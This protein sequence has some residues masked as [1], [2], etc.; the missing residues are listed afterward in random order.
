VVSDAPYPPPPPYGQPVPRPP[1]NGLAVAALVLGILAL[2]TAPIPLVNFLGLVLALVG[3]GLGIA[4]ITR[5]RRVGRR[6]GMAAWGLGLS[7]VALVVSTVVGF[8][9]VRYLGDLLDTVDPPDPSASIGEEFETDDGDLRITVTSVECGSADGADC[10]FSFDARNTSDR[11]L[12]LDN[13]KVKAVVDGEWVDPSL[14]GGLTL[15]PDASATGSGSVWL[16]GGTLE[17][18]AFDADDASSHSAV[19]VDV[20]KAESGQ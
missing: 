6:T 14:D 7:A 1:G 3:A 4:G 20:P 17:G 18:L 19:V 2:L 13:I 12:Y 9:T 10:T 15:A 5:G 8:L 11:T 16:S